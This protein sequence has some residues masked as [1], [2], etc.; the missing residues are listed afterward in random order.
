MQQDFRQKA[1]DSR[2]AAQLLHWIRVGGSMKESSYTWDRV[3]QV[4]PVR[5][6]TCSDVHFLA[7]CV[8]NYPTCSASRQAEDQQAAARRA[9]CQLTVAYLR[10]HARKADRPVSEQVRFAARAGQI[11]SLGKAYAC[12]QLAQTGFKGSC[13]SAIISHHCRAGRPRVGAAVERV[14]VVLV[15]RK[16][17]SFTYWA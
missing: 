6:G 15:P 5:V 16:R 8:Y 1:K 2:R 10:A 4:H 3:Y 14:Q 9:F 7:G 13:D 11:S 17:P 12:V